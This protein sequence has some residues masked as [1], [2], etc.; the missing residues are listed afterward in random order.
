MAGGQEVVV[1]TQT[2]EPRAS[3]KFY[4]HKI[5]SNVKYVQEVYTP[6]SDKKTIRWETQTGELHSMTYD[7]HVEETIQAILVAMKLS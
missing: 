6:E 3:N 2:N 1:I 7:A 5:P 4:G